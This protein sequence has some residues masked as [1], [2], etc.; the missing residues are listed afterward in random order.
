MCYM[1]IH[2]YYMQADKNMKI[3]IISLYNE[4]TQNIGGILQAYALNHVITNMGHEAYSIN[5]CREN[6]GNSL[7]KT[8]RSLKRSWVGGYFRIYRLIKKRI[9]HGKAVN[10]QAPLSQRRAVIMDFKRRFIPST[11]RCSHN[12]ISAY[13]ELYDAFVCGSDQIWNLSNPEYYLSF[14][15][16]SKTRISYAA[17]FVDGKHIEINRDFY[18]HYVNALDAISV[19]EKANC[20]LMKRVSG[21][22][23]E[24]A[25]DPTMLLPQG[26]WNDICAE[27]QFADEY[28]F[29]Y[30]LCD[31]R[32]MRG[33][34]GDYAKRKGLKL[35]TLP[36]LNGY[37]AADMGFGD[38]QMYDAGPREFISL[39]RHANTV[40]TDSFHCCVFSL[41]YHTEFFVFN[42]S[43]NGL[44]MNIRID[45]LLEMADMKERRINT[46]LRDASALPGSVCDY[47]FWEDELVKKREIST[48]YLRDNLIIKGKR[49]AAE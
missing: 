20:A 41:I 8:K 15:P 49:N 35:V 25:L 6:N 46:G 28:V 11:P 18:R 21:R 12:D 34:A 13:G 14:A 43:D 3:G 22:E 17:S 31:N 29:C 45:D 1:D 36:H 40:F 19:R 33:I 47:S 37:A 7:F 44:S 26:A 48:R 2:K 32:R 5:F 24:W 10:I 27:R 38:V 23:V 4:K 42:R 39:I 16:E 9:S 30:F